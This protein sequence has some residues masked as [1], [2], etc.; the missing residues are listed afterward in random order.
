MGSTNHRNLHYTPKYLA[1]AGMSKGGLI[2]LTDL[3]DYG[4]VGAHIAALDARAMPHNVNDEFELEIR[5]VANE[6]VDF[7]NVDA[8]DSLR[9]YSQTSLRRKDYFSKINDFMRVSLVMHRCNDSMTIPSTYSD[10]SSRNNRTYYSKY[11][12]H[13]DD[14]L[15]YLDYL[16]YLDVSEPVPLHFN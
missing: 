6:I 1:Q 5:C 10:H 12:E 16:T 3:E 11:M 14:L 2:K 7:M 13:V 4:L 15:T 9:E 8:I